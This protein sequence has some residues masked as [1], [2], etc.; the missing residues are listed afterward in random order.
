MK[1]RLLINILIGFVLTGLLFLL[2]SLSLRAEGVETTYKFHLNLQE[3]E[4]SIGQM[5]LSI[6]NQDEMKI[7]DSYVVSVPIMHADNF[8]ITL[9]GNEENNYTV[10]DSNGYKTLSITF[11]SPV[12][13][14][15]NKDLIIQFTSP[16][17]LI[18]T[19]GLK[20]LYIQNPFDNLNKSILYE[21]EYP[22]SFGD[23]FRTFE[24]QSI[25]EKDEETNIISIQSNNGIYIVWADKILVN[26]KTE[27][28]VKN[29]N[30]ETNSLFF[31]LP[32]AS[33]KQKVF[34]NELKNIDAAFGDRMNNLLGEV[35]V[36]ATTSEDIGYSADVIIDGELEESIYPDDYEFAFNQDSIFG[37]DV[38]ENTKD[39]PD[40]Y[41]KMQMFNQLLRNRVTTNKQASINYTDI[42]E[43]WKKL[44]NET[45]LNSFEFAALNVSFAEYLGM[46]AKIEYGYLILSPIEFDL[47]APQMWAVVNIDGDDVFIDGFMEDLTNISYFDINYIDR[48]NFGAWHPSQTYN[49]AA[50]LAYESTT[51]KVDA[52]SVEEKQ[53]VVKLQTDFI[54]PKNAPAGTPF[55]AKVNIKNESNNILAVNKL[56]INDQDLTANLNNDSGLVEATLPNKTTELTINNLREN[57]LFA[58]YAKEMNSKISF[59]GVDE[60][61]SDTDSVSFYIDAKNVVIFIAI[62][63]LAFSALGF[64]YLKA[65]KNIFK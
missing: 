16:E 32:S 57:N 24:T 36:D 55:S 60:E 35:H 3:G 20:Q 14:G 50:G 42:N 59:D 63:S 21:V 44:D 5:I 26:L 65:R 12:L 61:Y 53:Y 38:I 4:G 56:F 30:S 6:N 62:F 58:T 15:E 7:V 46:D 18:S 19:F 54:Y 39:L 48:V 22:K 34:F 25:T 40:N 10:T 17:L 9:G 45:T 43:L 27:V 41:S 28:N 8:L 23:I 51:I 37:K 29:E 49:P 11:E 1:S 47:S 2:F 31:N 64:L 33:K 13:P 52:S